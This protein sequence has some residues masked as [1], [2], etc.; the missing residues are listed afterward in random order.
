VA[1]IDLRSEK[2]DLGS[3]LHCTAARWWRTGSK[4]AIVEFNE[5]GNSSA[6]VA[7]FA[8]RLDLDKIVFL[9]HAKDK[10]IDNI[11]QGKVQEIWEIIM[12]RTLV[13]AQSPD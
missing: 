12:N 6:V 1:E 5:L 7:T 4:C 11:V 8:L 10:T 3:K 2:I 13:S 9:D